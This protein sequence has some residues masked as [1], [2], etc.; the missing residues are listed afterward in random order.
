MPVV[1]EC[2]SGRDEG[3]DGRFWESTGSKYDPDVL[4]GVLFPPPPLPVL[5]LLVTNDEP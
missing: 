5:D 4:W 2:G 3:S 1:G